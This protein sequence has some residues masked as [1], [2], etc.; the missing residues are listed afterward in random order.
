VLSGSRAAKLSGV[1][2]GVHW[3]SLD[4]KRHIGSA[5]SQNIVSSTGASD[6]GN[7]AMMSVGCVAE[8]FGSRHRAAEMFGS[9]HGVAETDAEE[10]TEA[11]KSVE[12]R[13]GE[14]VSCYSVAEIG[15]EVTAACSENAAEKPEKKTGG[16]VT[17]ACWKNVGETSDEEE[18]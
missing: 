2:C 7:T 9:R 1:V 18:R 4:E 10:E 11:L 13:H 5:T 17:A 12:E 3:G 16:E 6:E 8:M 14:K 15:V